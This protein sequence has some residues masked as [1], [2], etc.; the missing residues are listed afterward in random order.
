MKYLAL[1]ATLGISLGAV[2]C[3][4]AAAPASTVPVTISIFPTATQTVLPGATISFTATVSN[5][6]NTTV[7]WE[8]QGNV[9]GDATDG[10]IS[11]SG[12]Y[13]APSASA[14]INPFEVTVTAVSAADTSVTASTTVSIVLP[15][16]VMISPT[17][18]TLAAGATQQFTATT[19]PA[20]QAVTWEVNGG[21]GN[22]TIGTIT[23]AGL[24]TAPQVPP[25]GGTVTITAALQSAPT[26]FAVSTV[27]LEYSNFSL[28]NSYAFSLRGSDRSGLLLRAG[29][30]TA[31]GK[32]NI[33]AGTED[34]N[35]GINLVQTAVS[36]TGTYTIG[37][38]GRGTVTF[39][40]KFNG[41]TSGTGTA[42]QFSIVIVSAQQVQ[43]EEL[44][45]FASGSGEAD[46]QT[47]SLNTASFQGE[48]VF[49]FSGVDAS[50]E[51]I[52]TVGEFPANG[53]G[54][55]VPTTGLEDVNDNGALTSSAVATFS[56]QSVAANGRGLAT[57][58]GANY[59]FY[60]VS[61]ARAK[62][63][64]LT[65]S[66][67]VAGEAIQQAGGGFNS[68][69]L[70]GNSLLITNGTSTAGPISSAASFFATPSSGAITDGLLSQNNDGNVTPPGGGVFT[71]TYTVAAN[72]RGTAS[73]TSGETYVFYLSG[74]GQAIIQE[75]DSTAVADGTLLGLTGGPFQT[76]NLSG[77]YALQLRGVQA[78]VGEQDIV[79]QLNTGNGQVASGTVDIDTANA[80]SASTAFTPAPGVAIASGATYSI[81]NG[82]GPLNLTINGTNLEFTAYFL[83]SSSL[84]LLRQDTTDTRVLHGNL[85]QDVSLSAAIVSPNNVTFVVGVAGT[86]TVVATGNPAPT[87][88][89]SG[90]LPSGITFDALTGVLSG[91]P[92]AGTGGAGSTTGITT[93]AY[94]IQFTA[95][96]SAGSTAVQNFTLIVAQ[97]E[98]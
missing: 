23:P 70:G 93:M 25:A 90:T 62:F 36:F 92:A 39:Q 41:N 45:T 22:S 72:G 24:Y 28:Q 42:S 34:I 35:N 69:S 54:G 60:M 98:T 17:S 48:Y 96:N 21:A 67:V 86:F 65:A 32:G 63:V 68:T 77:G 66:P 15:S 2:A 87:L 76:S 57:L 85:Y 1:L 26:D 51:P 13:T 31:D 19:T 18:M 95:T 58:N 16:A 74:Q 64:S 94:P 46:L 40:D 55:G 44:D 79:G 78:G 20:N 3:K 9:N 6:T 33:T 4:S 52:S 83:S 29:T 38:D 59:S 61:A 91:T 12:L 81:S 37:P 73:F 89:Q 56:Y 8:V 50:G 53:T 84:Y 27:I 97:P 80:P 47:A 5:T 75:T 7:T 14:V 88:S 82:Q 11:T 71:G 10:T 49:D 43:M 30:V